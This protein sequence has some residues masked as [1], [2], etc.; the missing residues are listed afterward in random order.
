VTVTFD[1]SRSYDQDPSDGI[2]SYAF[3]FGMGRNDDAIDPRHL[4]Y[5]QCARH[6]PRLLS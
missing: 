3:D 6:L 5:L 4:A 2:A 1:A